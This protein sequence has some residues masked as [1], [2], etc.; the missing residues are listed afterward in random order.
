MSCKPV[1]TLA[2]RLRVLPQPA[3][4]TLLLASAWAQ[5]AEEPT[6]LPGVSVTGTKAEQQRLPG[7][8][9]VLDQQVLEDSRVFTVNEALR[10]LPGLNVRDEEGFGLR[11]NIGLR[12]LNPT[13]STKITLL[14]DG[15]PLAYAPYGDNASY[16]FPPVD[17]FDRIELVKGVG[18]LAHGPQT[19][20]GVLNF[21]TPQPSQAAR[22]FAQLVGGSRALRDA[23]LQYSQAGWLLDLTRK[24]GEGA[25]Q[26]LESELT[27]LNL[28]GHFR[29]D[30]GHQLTLKL[31]HFIEDSVVTYSGLTE[32]EYRNFGARY[33]PFK[34]DRFEIERSGASLT[35]A[36][37]LGGGTRLTT[38]LYRANF[39][40]DWWRQSS[41]TTDTQCGNAFRDARLAGQAVQVDA[42][43][44]AQGRL[45]DYQTTGIDSRLQLAHSLLGA[46]S[47][48]ELGL[49][50]HDERQARLQ[51][52]ASAPSGRSGSLAENNRRDTRAYSAFAANRVEVG[53]SLE[54]SPLLRYEWVENARANL[55]SGQ[56]GQDSLSAW[57]PGLGA[58]Y[59]LGAQTT[60]FG[61]VHRGFAP[62][63]A[64]DVIGGNGSLT[65]VRSEHSTNWE[66]GL[67]SE[68][69][70]GFSA[71]ATWFRNDFRR[72]IAVGSIAGGSTPL[73][74]GEALFQG[75]E[76]S[77]QWY[78]RSGWFG[79]AAFSWLPTAEQ[80]S[81]FRQVVGGAAIAGSAAGKRQ[82]YAPKH[83]A[84]LTV[85]WASDALSLQAELQQVGAQFS[86]FAN[87]EAAAANGQS[88][89]I[90]AYTLLNLAANWRLDPQW[91][92][93][94]TL[95][96]AADRDYI[97]DRTR[98]IQ[99]GM[100]RLLQAGM[101][102][103]F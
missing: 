80:S 76:L 30:G 29:F 14:E 102:Y 51:V 39:S 72:L 20:G 31:S 25:R 37:A 23:K 15:V 56:A 28:K 9:A 40:R 94:A 44:S 68:T 101:R 89:R 13:R 17:R 71:Q 95:K 93:F 99:T 100:P 4:L 103:R 87:S 83:T 53:E 6:P 54:I 86:D 16:Y 33:N 92:L 88:G 61:G 24:Q 84:S 77:A 60:L 82:P 42:C 65:E 81:P 35:H 55:L 45:R 67:R 22:G 11:P 62:P 38:Q 64:E 75:L 34:N 5:A 85:G 10:K 32:A 36:L 41:T 91:L 12:G 90:R 57:L 63:R 46:T 73:A 59:K 47:H 96:N 18:T 8:V 69:L 1:S 49:K 19:L 70:D 58:S 3:L 50:A 43:N 27:D 66:L 74:E 98:G 79:L 21:R 78:H 52:N 26:H 2:R 7:S 97:V 48:L